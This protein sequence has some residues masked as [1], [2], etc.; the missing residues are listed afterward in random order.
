MFALTGRALQ[1]LS[2]EV[3]GLHT[4]VYVIALSS[5]L[6]SLLA[7]LRDRLLAHSFGASATLD[8]YYAAFRIP[9]LIFVGV[10]ALVSVYILIPELT[11]RSSQ[12]QREYIDTVL[13]GFSLVAVVVS[14]VAAILAPA[15]LAALFPEITAAGSGATLVGLTRLMLLQP[16]FLGLSN[17]FGAI[18]QVRQ[19]YALY[20]LSP[21]LYNIGIIS[22]VVVFYPWWGL[23]GLAAG[24][25]LGALLHVGI[26]LPSVFSD[27]FIHALPRAFQPGVFLDTVKISIPRALALSMNQVSFIGL[28]ALAGTLVPGSIAVYMFASNLQAVPLAIIGASYSVAAFPILAAALSRGDRAFFIEHIAN[29]ARL[30]VFWSLP[31]TAI[32]IVLRAHIVRVILGSGAFDWTDTRL[33]AAVLALLSLSLTAQGITFLLVR[34]YY[35]SGRTF[36]PFAVALGTSLATVGLGA[37]LIGVFQN[38]IISELAQALLRVVDVPGSTVLALAFA[39][40]SVSILGSVVLIAHFERRFSGFL[41][42]VW[43]AWAES[44]VAAFLAGAAAYGMLVAVGPITL[45]STTLSVF[46]RGF[47]AGVFGIIVAGLVYALLRSRE[48]AEITEAIRGRVRGISIPIPRSVVVSSEESSP[49]TLQ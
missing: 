23:P 14:L 26:Q 42:R 45:A 5:L 22:G 44:A 6:S 16:I 18:T 39:S 36:V 29:A 12:E 4:A 2:Y 1:L 38:K 34:G 27:G 41:A 17:I 49:S 7:L 37:V 15:I 40:T 3:R 48:F 43:R 9:D 31:A 13:V 33:T 24:V 46:T 25:V 21:L 10:G 8:I 47:V 19:R 32:I 28:V 30:V 20:A 35:A 11:R